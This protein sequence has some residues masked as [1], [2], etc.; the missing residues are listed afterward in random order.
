MRPYFFE[1]IFSRGLWD[2]SLLHFVAFFHVASLFSTGVENKKVAG[3]QQK[4]SRADKQHCF[5]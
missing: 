2:M 5:P 3:R 1:I 4:S